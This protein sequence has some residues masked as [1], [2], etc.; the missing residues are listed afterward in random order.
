MLPVKKAIYCLARSFSWRRGGWWQ[1]SCWLVAFILMR[2]AVLL[3]QRSSLQTTFDE[4]EGSELFF[5]SH[6]RWWIFRYQCSLTADNMHLWNAWLGLKAQRKARKMIAKNWPTRG[7]E[8]CPDPHWQRA[9]ASF[10]NWLWVYWG[11]L[12]R[13]RVRLLQQH[14][15]RSAR[16]ENPGFRTGSVPT[17]LRLWGKV[18]RPFLHIY[19][20]LFFFF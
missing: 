18:M 4:A 17:K 16:S 2:N 13:G 11:A 9:L 8:N 14:W 3:I 12:H 5:R 20:F 15:T 6:W 19:L 10:S 1:D 7:L